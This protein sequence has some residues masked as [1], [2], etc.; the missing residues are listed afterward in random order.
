MDYLKRE[1]GMGKGKR[2][3]GWNELLAREEDHDLLGRISDF[4]RGESDIEEVKSDP[5]FEETCR[6]AEEMISGYNSSAVKPENRTF[7]L[8]NTDSEIGEIREEISRNN[9][10]E[11]SSQWVEEWETE[12]RK[13]GSEEIREFITSSLGGTEKHTE[14]DSRK[15]ILSRPLFIRYALSAA[16]V[17]TGV[18]FIISVLVRSNDPGRMFDKYYEPV[19]AISPVTRAGNTNGTDR[20]AE[21]VSLYNKGEYNAAATGFSEII[22]GDP[23]LASPRFYLGMSHLALGNYS[24]A[25]AHLEEVAG[26]EGEYIKEARWYLGL[27]YLKEGDEVKARE[28]FQFLTQSKGYYSGRAE[29]ILRRLR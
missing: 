3:D 4:F 7:I 22:S 17:L 27:I 24:Q 6:A 10:N 8:E 5:G 14:P 2:A 25:A 29:K 21:A 1:E 9:L 20:L 15:R 28:N 12:K 23:S 26:S 13:K 18:V 16:A 11:I 19:S